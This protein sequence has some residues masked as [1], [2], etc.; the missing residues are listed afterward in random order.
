MAH[1]RPNILWYCTDQQRFDTIG[2]LGNPH[3]RTPN[4]DRFVAEGTAFT[5]A[6]CQSPICT[7]SRASF[8]TGMY[9]SRVHNPRNGNGWV[10][11]EVAANLVTRQLAEAGYDGGLVGKLHLAG[12]F[13][14]REPRVNDGYRYFKYSHAPRNDWPLDQHDYA[15]WVQAQGV[16]P[17]SVLL[18][19]FDRRHITGALME[20]TPEQDNTPPEVH[21]TTWGT[22]ASI[23]F[24]N[25]PRPADQP[26]FLSVNVYDPHPPFNPPWAYYRRYD[27]D[28]LPGPY[29]RPSDLEH[30]RRLTASGI[31]F[32]SESQRPEAFEGKKVQAAYYAM[33]EQIDEQFG[34]LMDALEA[35]GQADRT[36][37]IFTSD[38]GESAGDYGL[39][40]KGCR[41]FDGLSRVPLIWRLPGQIQAGL[42]SDALVELTDIAPT[43]LEYAGLSVP[44]AMQGQTLRPIL[45]GDAPPDT[46]RDFVRCEYLDAVDK[47]DHTFATMYRDRRWKL[48]VYHGHGIGE[49]F[50]MQAD[51]H[52]HSSLWD[53]PDHQG[54]KLDLMQRS[55]DATVL[56]ADPGPPRVSS[57]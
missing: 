8:L 13:N 52:E 2:A 38:H 4:L 47:P 17:N 27:P 55:F 36:I 44:E 48:N 10:H 12:A 53:S 25:Q 35:S 34:R 19:N 9:P 6:Y 56:A 26:W 15:A 50:D 37:V 1:Q 45:S 43:L 3:V 31:D 7:P 23:E 21:Q 28:A 57:Y 20:P 22:E 51:P 14:G 16:D 5:H 11:R 40:Q 54:I 18:H 30:Q 24:I 42:R 29:F 32:Q 39:T 41:F 46:H 49:L 33:I